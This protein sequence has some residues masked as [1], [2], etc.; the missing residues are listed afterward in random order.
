MSTENQLHAKA[1]KT[2]RLVGWCKVRIE[3]LPCVLLRFMT[4]RNQIPFWSIRIFMSLPSG[5]NLRDSQC[6]LGSEMYYARRFTVPPLPPNKHSLCFFQ[7]KHGCY[8][9]RPS[10]FLQEDLVVLHDANAMN[11]ILHPHR[12]RRVNLSQ[13]RKKRKRKRRHQRLLP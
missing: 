6:Y 11:P 5:E 1:R 13:K 8:L 12:P 9:L 10:A 3:I 7:Q 4:S 2:H